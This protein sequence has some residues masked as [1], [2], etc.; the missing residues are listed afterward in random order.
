MIHPEAELLSSCEPL[1]PDKLGA[2]KIS[3]GISSF[4]KGEI[5]KKKGVMG[6]EQVQNLTEQ[7]PLVTKL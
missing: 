4:Q 3:G 2:F 7:M 1:K 5:G 6:P